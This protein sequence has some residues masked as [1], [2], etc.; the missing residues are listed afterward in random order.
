M[1]RPSNTEHRRQEIVLGLMSA[2]AEKGYEKASIQSI[3]KAA[4]LSPGLIHYHFKTKL[5]I[6]IALMNELSSKADERFEVLAAEANSAEGKLMAYIDAALA[7]GEGSNQQAVAAWVIIGAEAVRLDDVRSLYQEVIAKHT[8]TLVELLSHAALEA[9]SKTG[10]ELSKVKAKELATF[11]IAS[12]EG[13]YQIATTIPD[14]SKNYAAR[15]L[16]ESVLN[17][18]A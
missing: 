12:I 5:E 8:K 3:A 2:M 18:I 11:I 14:A 1:A 15:I 10:S 6:L 17:A 7:L 16:K 4:G 9:A 13:A